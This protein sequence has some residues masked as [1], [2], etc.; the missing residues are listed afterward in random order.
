LTETYAQARIGLNL[1]VVKMGEW[2]LFDRF[3]YRLRNLHLNS[4]QRASTVLQATHKKGDGRGERRRPPNRGT[5]FRPM[6]HC[7]RKILTRQEYPEFGSKTVLILG[8]ANGIGAALVEGFLSLDAK[9]G[10]WVTKPTRVGL[11]QMVC[12]ATT[13]MMWRC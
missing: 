9:V 2:S 1:S 3:A 11:G 13:L 5:F 7:S 10:N 4:P 12:A 8:G 6:Q